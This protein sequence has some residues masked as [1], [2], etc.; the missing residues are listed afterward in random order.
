MS[1]LL[2]NERGC[3]EVPI[4]RRLLEP[5]PG[6]VLVNVNVTAKETVV[7]HDPQQ[8]SA[9]QLVL[10]L[11]QGGGLD[12][13]IKADKRT[14]MIVEGICC[15]SGLFPLSYMLLPLT[16]SP[17]PPPHLPTAPHQIARTGFTT[18]GEIYS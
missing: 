16:L 12:A 10:A 9:Q 14:V 13:R 15:A 2:T 7:K 1:Q 6:V 8:T 17:S 18:C 4:I 5:L 11:N 3:A